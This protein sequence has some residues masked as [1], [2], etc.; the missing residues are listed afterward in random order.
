MQP[1]VSG[2]VEAAIQIEIRFIA[3][4]PNANPL[5]RVNGKRLIYRFDSNGIQR[6]PFTLPSC[7]GIVGTPDGGCWSLTPQQAVRISDQIDLIGEVAGFNHP[8]SLI[9]QPM[10]GSIWTILGM[11][12]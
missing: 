9:V 7:K 1:I 11:I 3:N 8:K 4:T 10:D 5:W 12:V 2:R 6:I